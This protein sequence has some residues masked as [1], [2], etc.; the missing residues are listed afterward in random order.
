MYLNFN[1]E[2]GNAI[3]NLITSS[4][5][6]FIV[7]VLKLI[8]ALGIS[9]T[10][11]AA[12]KYV[13]TN[14]VCATADGTLNKPFCTIQEAVD[15]AISGD[16]LRVAA[17]EY[18]WATVDKSLKL[19]GADPMTTV[20][21]GMS[22]GINVTASGVEIAYFT[23]RPYSANNTGINFNGG[24]G[25]TVHHCVFVGNN[26]GLYADSS[27]VNVFN[28]ITISNTSYG[29]DKHYGNVTLTSSIVRDGI[30]V[31]SASYS[32][33]NCSGYGNINSDPR[34]VDAAHGN[35]QLQPNSP[36]ID[37]G[38]PLIADRDPDGTRNDQGIYGGPGTAG[39]G[40]YATGGPIVTSLSITPSIL[41]PGGTI[42]I[43]ATGLAQ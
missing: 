7:I 18:E 4:I 39:F 25:G 17:G 24:S 34:F 12:T 38:S 8:F 26:K 15:V 21:Y 33:C 1:Q 19:L 3:M 28:V 10:I 13:N 40:P 31:S 6:H 22:H 16:T 30:A 41:T 5:R 9:D 14:A 29:I 32:N 2:C 36:S 23:F 43:Q 20:I 35:Y 11:H 42:K 27:T 37:A